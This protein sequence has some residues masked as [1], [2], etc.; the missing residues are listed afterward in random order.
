M[1]TIFYQNVLIFCHFEIE[2]N[3]SFVVFFMVRR[4]LSFVIISQESARYNFTWN[5]ENMGN[6]EYFDVSG[7][8][9]KC[10]IETFLSTRAV[11]ILVLLC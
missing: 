10:K 5:V 4:S 2:G 9:R 3:Q 6:F 1:W 7:K 11:Y 8:V